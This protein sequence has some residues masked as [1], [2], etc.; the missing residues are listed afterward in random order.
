M[1]ARKEKKIFQIKPGIT[2]LAQI[3]GYDMS[4]PKLLSDIDKLYIDKKSIRLDIMI[5]FAT[6]FNIMK[7]KIRDELKNEIKLIESK[8]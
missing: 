3:M 6:F 4:N 8:N 2:G 7:T 1:R 5:F